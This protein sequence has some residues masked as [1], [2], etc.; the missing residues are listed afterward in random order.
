M[1]HILWFYLFGK[2]K[3]VRGERKQNKKSGCLLA[4]GRAQNPDKGNVNT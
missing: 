2:C 4:G 3:P 1:L